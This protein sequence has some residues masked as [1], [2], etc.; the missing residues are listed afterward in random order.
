M[1][2]NWKLEGKKRR[3]LL[4]EISFFYKILWKIYYWMQ[5]VMARH[6]VFTHTVFRFLPIVDLK[7][8]NSESASITYNFILY[9]KETRQQKEKNSHF[10]QGWTKVIALGLDGIACALVCFV[11]VIDAILKKIQYMYLYL[12]KISF[13][14]ILKVY[15]DQG[16]WTR[17]II[18]RVREN[19][20]AFLSIGC[21]IDFGW[22]YTT[23]DT[24]PGI[25]SI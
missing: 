6:R 8:Y 24:I 21:D 23:I 15:L 1:L 17:R 14:R 13:T 5:E 20:R 2:K 4:K 7:I 18:F 12:Y 11:D 16:K 19:A 3:F 9:C 10:F 22:K 25:S